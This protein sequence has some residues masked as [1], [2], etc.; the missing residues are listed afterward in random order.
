MRVR[1]RAVVEL[2]WRKEMA[3]GCLPPPGRGWQG[4]GLL[5]NRGRPDDEGVVFVG[6]RRGALSDGS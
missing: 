5:V 4:G 3:G 6:D 2:V 1:G